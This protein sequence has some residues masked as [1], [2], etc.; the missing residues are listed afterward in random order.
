MDDVIVVGDVEDD[1]VTVDVE[2]GGDEEE[3]ARADCVECGT[4]GSTV[5]EFCDVGGV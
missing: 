5:A 4:A 1:V 2:T 3:I